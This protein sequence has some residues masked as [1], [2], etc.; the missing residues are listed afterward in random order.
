VVV[1]AADGIHLRL[2]TE[3]A[4]LR[5]AQ[6]AL[7]NAMRHAPGSSVRV[8]LR[9]AKKTVTLRIRDDGPG[10]DMTALPRTRRGMGLTTMRERAHEIGARLD[11]RTRPGG[12]TT[13]TVTVPEA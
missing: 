1:D 6:E 12:G 3:H 8:T 10:F 5:I 4:L 11:I 7:H 13:V 2:E 9:V